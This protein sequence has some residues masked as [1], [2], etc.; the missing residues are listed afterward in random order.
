MVTHTLGT[1]RGLKILVSV[2]FCPWPHSS[3][4][5]FNQ[6]QTLRQL[7]GISAVYFAKTLLVVGWSG[8][9]NSA[10]A[11]INIAEFKK[12]RRQGILVRLIG[13]E[14]HLFSQVYW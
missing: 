3:L 2:R 6:L 13:D 12:N 1:V 11:A 4:L 14:F 7:E 8:E 9:R 10:A 5:E